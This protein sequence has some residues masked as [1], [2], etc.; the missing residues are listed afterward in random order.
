MSKGYFYCSSFFIGRMIKKDNIMYELTHKEIKER[1]L[2]ILINYQEFCETNDL[3]MY[4]CAGT[5]LGAV[6]HNG[7]I[8]WD[9]DID[10][11][12]D[13][14]SYDKVMELA[15]KQSVF[16]GHYKITEFRFGDSSYPFIKVVDLETKMSQQFENDEADYLWIDV[17]PMDGLPADKKMQKKLYHKVA[18]IR[19][20]QML[21]FAKAGQ[22]RTLAKRILK[23]LII[24]FAKLYGLEHA[25]K[26]LDQLSQTYDFQKTGWIGDV[27]W[28]DYGKET[29][30]VEEYFQSTTVKFEGH[31]FDTMKCWNKY[32]SCLYGTDYMEIPPKSKQVNH[33]LKAWLR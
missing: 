26:K 31:E 7:F 32:L 13:R 10:V 4:L 11:C 23:P 24:P 15:R 18:V 2:N 29:L 20:I 3:K 22:G 9:D 6:R 1:L 14:K 21:S 12:M 27:M 8:P 19:E 5:L 25:N 28:G 30:T 33:C 17:F 16:N